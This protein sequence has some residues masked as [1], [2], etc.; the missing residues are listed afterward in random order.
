MT[1]VAGISAFYHD[2]A[3]CLVKDGEVIAAAQEERLTRRKF[4]PALPVNAYHA[5]LAEVGLSPADVDAMAFYEVP[6]RKLSRILWSM[7]QGIGDLRSVL[8]TWT[9]KTASNRLLREGLSFRGPLQ[10]YLFAAAD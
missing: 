9:E 4:D 6:S 8:S 1:I 2:A 10:S 7:G 3:A 5:C